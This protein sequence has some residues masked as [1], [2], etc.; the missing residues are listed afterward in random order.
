MAQ[1]LKAGSSDAGGKKTSPTGEITFM[2]Q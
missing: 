1:R 2:T